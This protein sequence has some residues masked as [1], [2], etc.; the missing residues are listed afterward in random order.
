MLEVSHLTF[1]YPDAPRPALREATFTLPEGSFTL[2]AGPSGSGKSTLLR[3]FNGLVPHFSGGTVH[4]SVRVAGLDPLALGPQ[5]M[6][7]LVGF[8]Q[9]DPE[10]QCITGYVED[11]I[12]FGLENAGWPREAIRARIAELL[13]TLHLEHLRG[14]RLETLSGGEL[15]RVIIASV[16]AP[17]P[18]ILVLDEPTSQLDPASAEEVLTLIAALKAQGLTVVAAE[19][20]LERLLPFVDFIVGMKEGGWVQMGTPS[21]P[22]A[23]IA[24]LTWTGGAAEP[25]GAGPLAARDELLEAQHLTVR[26]GA[27]TA[28]EDVSLTLR[29]GELLVLVGPNGAGKSTLLRTLV[30]LQKP[31]AGRVLL[32][33]RP[34]SHDVAQNTRQV[35]YLPQDP[36]ALLFAERV[37]DELSLT[38][39]NHRLDPAPIAPE[40]LLD[41]L[42]LR[43]YADAYPRD[44]S[45]GQ[46]Q[47]VA[48]AALLV[49]RPRVLLLD[50]PT[51]GLDLPTRRALLELLR[52][53]REQGAGILIATHDLPLFTSAADRV[54]VLE[55]GRLRL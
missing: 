31:A 38:L 54:L 14:R 47:R 30:G 9:Q 49:T 5:R 37:C 20:R 24:P 42:G 19:H 41:A 45:V 52:P 33:G 21:A 10:A 34:L 8:V 12:A 44:L 35:A 39:R 46:R 40:T 22:P 28:L 7:A 26:Y 43:P 15:Q 23:F 11:E 48:L 2:V 16:L 51:R 4:G 17:R 53:W 13:E 50:E 6:S 29:A 55:Q 3:L 36:D 25:R 18:R 1:T 32:A 27:F